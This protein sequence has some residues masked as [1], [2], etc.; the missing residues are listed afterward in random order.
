[1]PV[2]TELKIRIA[3]EQLAR[4]KRHALFKTHQLSR[5][6]T[7]RLYN[8]YFDTPNLELHQSG[9]ALRLRRSGK[10][11]LQTLKGGGSVEGGLHRRNE[12]ETA[13]SDPELDFSLLQVPEWKDI[14]PR[15]LRKKLQPVFVTDFS[16]SSRMLSWQGA[17][18]ELCMDQGE[19]STEH[20]HTP[21]CE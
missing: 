1:M 6:V 9:M 14:L 3:P 18:I 10:Q 4:L 7:R 8:I 19:I 11:W 13:V 21:I 5:P 17:E 20:L 2:E 15:K 12:L 16:R